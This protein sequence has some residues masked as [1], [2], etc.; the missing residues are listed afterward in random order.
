MEQVERMLDFIDRSPSCYQAVENAERELEAAGFVRLM[1]EEKW[2]LL[3]GG[4][5]YVSRN[6]SSLIAFAIPEKS[7]AKR[8]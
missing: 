3:H 8:S 4:K 6:G 1:E 5:Y 7:E 2:E